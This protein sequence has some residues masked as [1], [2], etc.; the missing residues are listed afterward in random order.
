VK[1]IDFQLFW[2]GRRRGSALLA[3][4][5]VVP[6]M[7]LLPGWL[8]RGCG[9]A[10]CSSGLRDGQ[11]GPQDQRAHEYEQLLHAI[12]FKGISECNRANPAERE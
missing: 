1:G 10:S 2:C 3:F 7:M 6:V 4:V 11:G 9:R 12:S 5:M 8:G